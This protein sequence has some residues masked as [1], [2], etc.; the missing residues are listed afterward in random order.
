MSRAFDRVWRQTLIIKRY[1]VFGIRGKILPWISDFLQNRSIRVKYKNTL[2]DPFGLRHGR[3][4]GSV[5]SQGWRTTGTIFWAH[6]RS[7]MVGDDNTL[8]TTY[9]S[10]VRPILEYGFAVYFCA[11][12]AN[13]N[14]LQRVQLSVARTIT[15]LRNS[16]PNNIVFH[17]NDLPPLSMRSY[18]LEKYY[19]KLS[20]YN[21]HHRRIFAYLHSWLNNRRFK[22]HNPFFLAVDMCLFSGNVEP[23]SLM[24]FS[25]FKFDSDRIHFQTELLTRVCKGSDIPE[26][27]RQIALE[28]IHGILHSALKIY[29]DGSMGGISG[30][31]VHIETPDGLNSLQFIDIASELVFR[32]VW[33]LIDSRAS[34]QHLSRCT[35][36]GD[37]TTRNILDVVVRLSS[38]HSIYFQW[39]PSHIGLNGNEIADSLA[40]STTAEVLR[41]T[42]V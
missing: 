25:H 13:L 33:I 39:V 15:G 37:M 1:D 21:D 42:L 17:G 18:I 19:N 11:S 7:K 12:E 40:K 34:I 9:I 26:F 30:S 22:K 6:Q 5:L 27:T 20:S 29:T 10:L 16:C 38:R 36:V 14:K 8:R 2:P 23:H 32:D 4:Q 35:T 28:T 31:G 24:P 3:P 41:V